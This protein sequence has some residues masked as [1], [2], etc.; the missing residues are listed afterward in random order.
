MMYGTFGGYGLKEHYFAQAWQNL[1][2][3]IAIWEGPIAEVM[4][5]QC[6]S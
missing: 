3:G 6:Q 5:V 1:Q 2:R 4:F